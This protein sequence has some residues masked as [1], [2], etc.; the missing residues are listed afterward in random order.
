MRVLKIAVLLLALPSVTLAQGNSSRGKANSWEFT[1]GGI[2]QY[3]ERASGTGGS[4]LDMSSD[5]GFAFNL[6]YHF[7]N[8]LALGAD[9]DFLSP[10][11]TAI[12]ADENDPSNTQR[13]DH[14]LSQF[15]GRLKGTCNFIDGPF[16]PFVEVGLGWTYMDSNVAN[17]PPVTGCW[18]D[19]W[20]GYICSGFYQTFSGTDFSYGG[21]LGARYDIA[22]GSFIRASD[23]LQ[24]VNN[25]LRG[26]AAGIRETS[27]IWQWAAGNFHSTIDSE[28][29]CYASLQV[30]C[31]SQIPSGAQT[32]PMRLGE[33]EIQLVIVTID[34]VE[35]KRTC[36]PG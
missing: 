12:I 4:S 1:L 17:G 22:G 14:K 10:S 3:G 18:W 24:P 36:W 31:R 30:S 8:K 29:V 6:G 32:N 25:E 5:L 33:R 19:P 2:Y 9:F 23:T 7:T 16:T 21:S 28:P 35:T 26:S 27:L 34:E 15:N 20:W 11:Y 13:I